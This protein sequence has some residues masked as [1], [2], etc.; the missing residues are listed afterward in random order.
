[1][2]FGG[3]GN[4]LAFGGGDADEIHGDDGNDDLRGSTGNDTLYGGTGNDSLYGG[5]DNDLLHGGDGNDLLHTGPGDD[6]VFGGF[7]DDTFILSDGHGSNGFTGGEDPTGTDIDTINAT[8]LTG[9]VTLSFTGDETGTLTNGSVTATFSE[10]EAIVLGSGNDSVTGSSG[11]DVVF[12][13]SGA[14]TVTGGLG[15]DLIDLGAADGAA[16]V[17]VLTPFLNG[18]DTITGFE[19]PVDLGG[20]FYIGQDRLD[21]SALTD[22]G[23]NPVDTGD[24]VVIDDGMGNTQLVFPNGEMIWLMGVTPPATRLALGHGDPSRPAA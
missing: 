14:D 18:D 21:V 8:T 10:I 7:G 4:D 22:M 16:D 9:D 13:G 19:G 3:G 15:N 1:M 24:V 2:I 17:V 6:T 20:G 23:G 11:D 12:T 5:G